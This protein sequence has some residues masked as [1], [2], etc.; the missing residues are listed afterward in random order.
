[1]KRIAR[2]MMGLMM[3]LLPFLSRG[4]TESFVIETIGLRQGLPTSDIH[5][6]F[7]DANGYLWLG[8][9]IGLVRYDG[10][11]FETISVSQEGRWLGLVNAIT[12]DQ[13]GQLW[14]GTED[15]LFVVQHGIAHA[16]RS[17]QTG[18]FVRMNHLLFDQRQNLW[19]ATS[20]GAYRI[21][22][23]DLQTLTAN[24]A[25]TIQPK[26]LPDYEKWVP[27]PADRRVFSLAFDEQ[28]RLYIGG[29]FD[30]FRYQPG[31]PLE[32]IWQSPGPKVEIQS[33][34][35]RSSN[36]LMFTTLGLSCVIRLRNGQEE[37]LLTDRISSDVIW[38]N[39]Q[40]WH[41][42]YG[43][44]HQGANDAQPIQEINLYRKTSGS[45][46]K[47]LLDQEGIFWIATNEGLLKLR[48][49]VFERFPLPPSVAG[50]EISGLGRFQRQL[51]VGAPH[52]RLFVRKG[53]QLQKIGRDLT[54]IAGIS[55]IRED[56]QGTLWLA[57]TYQGLFSFD[58]KT[59]RKYTAADGLGDEGFNDIFPDKKGNLWAVGDVGITQILADSAANRRYRLRFYEPVTNRYKFTIFYS[60]LAAPDGT[61]WLASDYGLVSFRHGK[62]THHRLTIGPVTVRSIRKIAF[63]KRGRVWLATEGQGLLQG[64]FTGGLFRPIRQYTTRDGLPSNT[65][66]D[67]LVDSKGRIWAGGSTALTCLIADAA[68]TQIRNFDYKDGFF[69]ESFQ[70]PH[71]FEYPNDTLWISSSEGLL[72][73]P[74]RQLDQIRKAP[75][76]LI[77]RVRLRD[78]KDAI[79]QYAESR[80]VRSGLPLRCQLPAS[81]NALTFGFALPSLVNPSF[82]RY[83]FRL[84]GSGESWRQA[85]GSDR[86]VTYAGLKPGSYTFR[87][88]GASANGIWSS[89]VSFP[90][91]I[92]PPVWQRAWFIALAIIG[93]SLGIWGFIRYREQR[94]KRREVE[95]NRLAQL[96]AD[97]ET[98][99]IRAQMNPHF[100]FNCL[101][102]IQECILADHTDAAYRY[103]SKFSRLLRMVLEE[104][105]RNF[106]AIQH[107]LELIRLYLELESMRFDQP[108]H[109]SIDVDPAIDTQN[110]QIP[111]LLLQPLVENAIWHGLIHQSEPR[112]LRL[113]I[114]QNND[115][116]LT[117]IIE[118]NGVG[119][120][121][122]AAL[123]AQKLVTRSTRGLALVTER[124]Q[125]LEPAGHGRGSLQIE[126]LVDA[127]GHPAGT[128]VRVQLPIITQIAVRASPLYPPAYVSRPG[129]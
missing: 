98:R 90:F 80:D 53:H 105:A 44:Y 30:L 21:D 69:G 59:A 5:A 87:M 55:A 25:A 56:A 52:G 6:L 1:M 45:F 97:L 15:G 113:E 40:F 67:V 96:I 70:N 103:L 115:Q 102:S 35:V 124:L 84:D 89:V 51:L 47:M 86:S 101:N 18:R 3:S 63:D 120:Q 24:P 82:N 81:L 58:G 110:W 49:S 34:A 73:F 12:E 76:S 2:L 64:H 11:G 92:L 104:S 116:T 71:L 7:R 106:H 99:A 100:I 31:K 93:L 126:D 127:E 83:R 41:L 38:Q 112:Q 119:R 32:Q 95:K 39:N 46:T 66:N 54:T 88:V 29:K 19:C 79:F 78:G 109:Y 129:H 57:T 125:L 20:S 42:S 50:N 60:G 9:D 114:R 33:L 68:I 61:L 74:L 13:N 122:A 28:N 108:M 85:S 62:F 14:V 118:D 117:C 48:R 16:V 107:E 36:D 128:C 26:A 123:S 121:R 65:F 43:L 91:E 77:T 111:S 27:K 37:R 17:L 75:S 22:Q 94:I 10:Y 23:S 4:Q 72:R 8:T